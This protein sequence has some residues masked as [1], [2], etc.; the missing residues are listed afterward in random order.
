MQVVSLLDSFPLLFRNEKKRG[1]EG[2]EHENNG[3]AAKTNKQKIQQNSKRV[4]SSEWKV[5]GCFSF[6]SV[7]LFII[8]DLLQ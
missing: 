4:F 7:C 1:G 2:R 3:T 6:T 8:P 5:Y